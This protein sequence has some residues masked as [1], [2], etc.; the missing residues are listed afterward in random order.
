MPELNLRNYQYEALNRTKNAFMQRYKRP[1]VVLPCGAGKTVLFAY[2]AQSAQ[3]K[4]NTVWF[5]VHRKELMDQTV[6]TFEKFGIP[7]DTIHIGMVGTYANKFDKYPEPDFIIFDEAHFSMARTWQKII[8]RFPSVPIVGLT[9]T[10]AR[11][12]GKPLGAIYDRMITGVT[13]NELI[14]QGYLSDYKYFAPAVA[15]LS[16]LKRKGSDFNTEQA[17]ELLSTRAVFGDVI[18]HYR[19]HADG[20]QTICYCSSIKH[21]EAMAEEFQANGINA[22]HF[23]GNTPKK[24][25]DD[26]IQRF[27]DG[28]IKILC[29]VDLISVGFDVPDCWCCILLRP[30]MSTALYIQQACRALRPQE[31]K[32]AIILD[33]VGNYTRHGLPDDDRAWSLDSKVKPDDKYNDDGTLTVRQC[34]NCYYTFKS[35]PVCPNCGYKPEPTKQEIENIKAI[36]LEEIKRNRRKQAEDAVRDKTID[37]CKTLQE[38]Q[39]Y[40]KLNGKSSKWAYFHWKRKVGKK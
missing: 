11:L 19:E 20:L 5:L 30:T 25:R 39:S 4:N 7:L 21:S 26:I 33:H 15:D 28:D 23:D 9:A 31:G 1:L 34:E 14:Q 36:K 8:E 22:V 32:T 16:A 3:A 10:P 6:A 12:D 40:A 35:A 29:N 24:T 17:S 27:R 2:M 38:F 18:K 37:E 13:T